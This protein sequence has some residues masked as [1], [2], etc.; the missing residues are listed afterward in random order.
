MICF[1]RLVGLRKTIVVM[2][3][4]HPRDFGK[5]VRNYTE[6]AGSNLHPSHHNL[7]HLTQYV[8]CVPLTA[9]PGLTSF[10]RKYSPLTHAQDESEVTEADLSHHHITITHKH[11]DSD[12]I[13]LQT[14]IASDTTILK[15]QL[16]QEPHIPTDIEPDTCDDRVIVEET[17]LL[18]VCAC[19]CARWETLLPC[20]SVTHRDTSDTQSLDLLLSSSALTLLS[21]SLMH[22]HT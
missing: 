5:Y 3:T 2:E 9:M 16:Q 17:S 22:P 10:A 1:C 20:L 15:K 4:S 19:E 7:P 11:T 13:P 21:A 8:Q 12:T 14:F 6:D 18:K